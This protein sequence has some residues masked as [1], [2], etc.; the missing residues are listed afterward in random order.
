MRVRV[1]GVLRAGMVCCS[2]GNPAAAAHEEEGPTGP[3]GPP[4]PA[5]PSGPQGQ[6]GPVGPQ[7]PA[8]QGGISVQV[9]NSD[10]TLLG[11]MVQSS[12]WL[13]VTSMGCALGIDPTNGSI[14]LGSGGCTS[15]TFAATQYLPLDEVVPPTIMLPLS[16]RAVG[17][18]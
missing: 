16:M 7:G 17:V 12:T 4:G 2:P 8:G 5:G 10:G 9:F 1:I 11:V 15:A 13:Y 3:A 6:P 14:A 18:P